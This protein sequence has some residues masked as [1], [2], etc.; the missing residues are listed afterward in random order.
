MKALIPFE[1][2]DD[3]D[4][5]DCYVDFKLFKGDDCIQLGCG[6]PVRKAPQ[7]L[8]EDIAVSTRGENRM[9]DKSILV[10]ETPKHCGEC[11][12]WLEDFYCGCKKFS[13]TKRPKDCPLKPLP[14]KK[15][16]LE[17]WTGNLIVNRY[18]LMEAKGYNDCIDEI[19][20]EKEWLK[21]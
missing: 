14:K 9:N 5:E 6:M 21:E 19:L 16:V 10:V 1:V 3:L 12:L 4:L 20:G 15:L 7:H 8:N 11:Q 2:D 17:H 13:N 18:E